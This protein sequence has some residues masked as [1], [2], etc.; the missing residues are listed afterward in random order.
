M[1]KESLPRTD[2]LPL[3]PP[4]NFETDILVLSDLFA[5]VPSGYSK[6]R[7]LSSVLFFPF[8]SASSVYFTNFLDLLFVS[9]FLFFLSILCFLFS[10]SGKVFFSSSR[11]LA[12][13]K[14]LNWWSLL[15]VCST[16]KILTIFITAKKCI[17]YYLLA[18]L[19]I[20][21]VIFYLLRGF[22]FY[23]LISPPPKCRR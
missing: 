9:R 17:F 4:A 10:D 22:L 18:V 16:A 20:H 19:L 5:S 21:S 12:V 2:W 1:T 8:F 11:I 3:T 15:L 13:R 14:A 7:G 6:R 23:Y